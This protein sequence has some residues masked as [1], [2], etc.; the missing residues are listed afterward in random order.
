VSS[1][2]GFR[3]EAIMSTASP[4]WLKATVR[5]IDTVNS[6]TGRAVAWL[7]IPMVASLVYEVGSRYLFD[8]PTVWAYDMTFMLYG[9]FFMLGAAYTLSNK[10]HIRTDSFYGGWSVRRQ[11]WVDT[12]CYLVFFFPPLIAFQVVT[13]DYFVRS[14]ELSERIMT[15]PWMPI[16]YPFKGVMPLATALLLLQGVSEFLK[17]IHAALK[18]EWL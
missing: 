18:G 13:W 8:A 9:T 11:G 6:W 4:S 14:Y 1:G 2:A 15:S 7:I 12:I 3:T 16:V 5:T 17:S 10:G